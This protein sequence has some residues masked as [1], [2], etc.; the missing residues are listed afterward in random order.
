M[1]SP[2]DYRRGDTVPP[3]TLWQKIQI[4]PVIMVLPL[5]VALG[6]F[7]EN[8]GRSWLRAARTAAARYILSAR[9]WTPWELKSAL[10]LTTAQTYEAWA[11]RT[12]GAEVLTDELPEGAKLHWVGPRRVDRVILYFHGGGYM[13]PAREEHFDMLLTLRR[14]FKGA[15]G[16]ALLNYALVPEHPFPKQVR[17]ALVAVYHLLDAGTPP[18]DLILAGDSAGGNL[19]LQTVAQLLHPHPSLPSPPAG[20]LCL[21]GLL[22]LSP[23]MEFRTDAPSYTRNAAR[24]VLP[25]CTYRLFTDNVLPGVTPEL[26]AHLEPAFAAASGWWRGLGRVA[27]RVL[28]VAGE[29]EALLDPIEETARV[30]AE[31][32][33]DTMV[34]VLPRGVHDDLIS[35][36]GAGEGREG[37]D[38]RLV[39]SWV[40]KTLEL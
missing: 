39:V 2:D 27:E 29:H 28:V 16:F 25:L 9:A 5:A 3:L 4:A 34:F 33:Q 30:I 40:A 19:A 6:V 36:F 24:D 18:S 7:R 23:W 32:V 38:Y 26:R 20:P 22:L 31:E 13:L 11:R 10:G 1:V 15:V 14:D 37:E 21:G 35:A 12:N 17:Q 8:K